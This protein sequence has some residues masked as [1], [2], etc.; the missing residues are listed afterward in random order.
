M[1]GNA[2]VIFDIQ[3]IE[4]ASELVSIIILR[5]DL[6]ASARAR[7]GNGCGRTALSGLCIHLLATDPG[8]RIFQLGDSGFQ[9]LSIG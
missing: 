6:A 9:L 2:T 3:S 7:L 5:L 1:E 4:L 8:Q